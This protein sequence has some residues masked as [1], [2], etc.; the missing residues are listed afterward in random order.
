MS[1]NMYHGF[2]VLIR[3]RLVDFVNLFF[4]ADQFSAIHFRTN[5][6]CTQVVLPI[7]HRQI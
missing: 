3:T 1:N 2:M 4:F 6:E 7:I 5:L